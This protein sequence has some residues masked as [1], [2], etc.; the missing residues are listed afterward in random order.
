MTQPVPVPR[1]PL[2]EEIGGLDAQKLGF[3]TSISSNRDPFHSSRDVRSQN[4]G[5]GLRCDVAVVPPQVSTLVWF[6][7]AIKWL[8]SFTIA[9]LRRLR[10]WLLLG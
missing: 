9:T 3:A 8:A 5:T 7:C 10:R 2:R 1:P 4:V 6:K